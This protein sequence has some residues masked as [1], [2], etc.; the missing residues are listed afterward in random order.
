MSIKLLTSC[1]SK[2]PLVQQVCIE[3]LQSTNKTTFWGS[4]IP[5]WNAVQMRLGKEIK[6]C[7]K[8]VTYKLM[9]NLISGI[10]KTWRNG[11]VLVLYREIYFKILIQEVLAQEKQVLLRQGHTC[12]RLTKCD[13]KSLGKI[14]DED[15]C[16]LPPCVSWERDLRAELIQDRCAVW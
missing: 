5:H 10:W 12:P 1:S 13:K 16:T 7:Q 11:Y 2:N 3:C 14:H 4:E 8:G 15:G 6:G 9:W